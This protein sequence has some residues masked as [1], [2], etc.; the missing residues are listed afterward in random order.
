[1]IRMNKKGMLDDLFDYIITIFAAIF[2]LMFLGVVINGS[3]SE[4]Q[5]YVKDQLEKNQQTADFLV[6]E[7]IFVEQGFYTMFLEQRYQDVKQYGVVDVEK[8]YAQ[9]PYVAGIDSSGDLIP[10]VG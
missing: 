6:N 9:D 10:I 1:M 7:R 8:L 3:I 5:E 4:R 2:I